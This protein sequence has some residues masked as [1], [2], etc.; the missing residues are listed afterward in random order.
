MQC[1]EIHDGKYLKVLWDE[2][3][4]IIGIDWKEATSSMTDQDFKSELELFAGLVER[5]KAQGILVDVAHFRH[6]MAPEVQEWRVN[7]ISTRYSAAG[8]RRFAF[9]HAREC[10][11]SADDEPIRARREV[12]DAGVPRHRSSNRMA[13]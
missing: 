8:V 9:R 1:T 6:K 7:N 12:P 11:D 3:A 4:R 5:K 10:S 13:H 2:G